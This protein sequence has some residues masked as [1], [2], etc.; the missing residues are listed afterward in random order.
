MKTYPYELAVQAKTQQE[1]DQKMQALVTILNTLSTTELLK[2]AEVV[3]NP[4]QLAL[5]K[6][7]LL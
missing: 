6:T 3:R 2:V 7:K 1:A 5:I 4:I